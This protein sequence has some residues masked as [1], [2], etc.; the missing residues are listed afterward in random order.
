M[1]VDCLLELNYCFGK[2]ETKCSKHDFTIVRF[3]L[4][5]LSTLQIANLREMYVSK[6]QEREILSDIKNS[7]EM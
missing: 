1:F 2:T 3:I 5:K 6:L 4:T 7:C